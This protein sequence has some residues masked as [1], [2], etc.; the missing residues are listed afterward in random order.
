[1]ER[2][3]GGMAGRI[4]LAGEGY[5]L[6]CGHPFCEHSHPVPQLASAPMILCILSSEVHKMQILCAVAVDCFGWV[7]TLRSFPANTIFDG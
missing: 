2:K 3:R 7:K 1:M 6:I 4:S 5:L